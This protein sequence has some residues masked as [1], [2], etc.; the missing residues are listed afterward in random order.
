MLSVR[1]PKCQ[2]SD[3]VYKS[4]TTGNA[5]L[6]RCK[7]CGGKWLAIVKG[8]PTK[9]VYGEPHDLDMKDLQ[10]IRVVT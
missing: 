8:M 6:Y 4:D 7:A 1:C 10:W 3:F 2:S 5:R 9:G